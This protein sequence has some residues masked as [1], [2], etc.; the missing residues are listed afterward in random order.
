MV[1]ES[2]HLNREHPSNALDNMEQAYISKRTNAT[3]EIPKN[4]FPKEMDVSS[5]DTNIELK[6]VD[7]LNNAYLQFERDFF[8]NPTLKWQHFNP[9][10]IKTG[11]PN[12]IVLSNDSQTV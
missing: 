4:G 10:K 1:F 6:P 9:Q 7:I 5:T 12:Y 11:E 8:N 2:T 3:G